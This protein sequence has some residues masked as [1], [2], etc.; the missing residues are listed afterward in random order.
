MIRVLI[1]DDEQLVRAGLRKIL[2]TADNL[3]VVAEARDGDEAI[4]AV[5]RHR[6]DVVLIDVRMPGTDGLTSA[7]QLTAGSDVPKVIMLTTF[8]LDEHVH[9]TLRAGAVGFLLKDTPPRDST[10]RRVCL[11]RWREQRHCSPYRQWHSGRMA[12]TWSGSSPGARR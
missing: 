8:D 4:R 2:E 7:A 5:A 11:Q 6:P 3:T 9:D 10:T 12:P 1:A